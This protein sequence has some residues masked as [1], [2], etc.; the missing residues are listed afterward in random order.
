VREEI[1]DFRRARFQRMPLFLEQDELLRPSGKSFPF[2]SRTRP[3]KAPFHDAPPPVQTEQNEPCA[4][5]IKM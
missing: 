4:R 5:S 1:T 3:R 2:A